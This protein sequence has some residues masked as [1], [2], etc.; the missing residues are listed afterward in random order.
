MAPYLMVT[1]PLALEASM[2]RMTR[3]AAKVLVAV[4]ATGAVALAAD[5]HEGKAPVTVAAEAQPVYSAAVRPPGR[6]V[7]S[8][9]T[10]PRGAL[11]GTKGTGWLLHSGTRHDTCER[12]D[13]T[14]GLR[15]VCLAW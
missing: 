9:L 7:D 1:I 13:A 15:M 14:F 5:A 2:R 6:R 4:C 3:F 10:N 12:A 11:A 8:V